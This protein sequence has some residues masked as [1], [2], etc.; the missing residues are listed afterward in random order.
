MERLQRMQLNIAWLK[1]TYEVTGM[2]GSSMG[3]SRIKRP[4]QGWYPAYPE[5][6]GYLLET[7]CRLSAANLGDWES[8]ID[9]SVTWLLNLQLEDGAFTGGLV[10]GNQRSVFNSAMIMSGL[11]AAYK[12]TGSAPVLGTIKRTLDWLLEEQNT[13]GG[14]SRWS[15]HEGY[16]PTY[17]TRVL[18]SLAAAAQICDGYRISKQISKGL[19]HYLSRVEDNFPSD[20]SLQPGG[21][22]FSHTLAYCIRGFLESATWLEDQSS[23][24]HAFSMVDRW[25]SEVRNNGRIAGAY[26]AEWQGNY[27]FVCVPG[28]FQFADLLFRC[29][30]LSGDLQYYQE[31]IKVLTLTER[32]QRINVRDKNIKGAFPGSIPFWGP[33][34]RFC[35]P[36]WGAK[37]YLDA[38]CRSEELA[39]RVH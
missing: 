20:C 32:S 17:Y 35:Y 39:E 37:F 9:S 38:A 33:Y 3:Y 1:R 24:D 8:Y 26:D 28:N 34:L 21:L 27:N 19:S 31:G 29:Y 10:G 36:N 12:N 25:I 14:F 6:S 30:E 5:T 16:E 15:Y 22:N 4:W 11:V 13:H 23:S 2:Q 7:L 18:W